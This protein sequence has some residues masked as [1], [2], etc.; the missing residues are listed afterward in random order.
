MARVTSRRHALA[1]VAG[2]GLW[3]VAAAGSRGAAPRFYADD[4]L[5]R[6]PETQD[7]S[8][9][10]PWDIDL[11]VDLTTNLF[12]RPGDAALDVRAQNVNTVDEVPDSGWFTNRIGVEPLSAAQI[13]VGPA[14]GAGPAPGPWTVIRPKTSGYAP[15]FTIRDSAGETW[16]VSFDAPGSPEAATGAILVANK[17]FWA[18]GYH[19]VENHLGRI[20]ADQIRIADT[21]MMRLATGRRRPMMR[22]DVDDVLRRSHR[23]ADGSY[24]AVLGRLLPGQV[25]GGFRYYGTRPDDPNDVVPHEHRRELRALKVF[26]AWTNL[27][28]MKAG[29]TLDTVI[30]VDGRG[31]VRHYLQDIGS[32]FGAGALGPHD[33]DEGWEYLYEGKPLLARLFTLGLAVPR[34]ATVRYERHPSV[35][36]FEGEAF[37]PRRW[38]PRVP[39]AAFLRARPADDFWAARRV[40]AFSDALIDAAVRSGH[41]TDPAAERL[42][43]RVLVQR[44]DKI[45]RAF[46]PAVNPVVDVHMADD[47][48]V[49]FANAAVDA[50]VADA[51]TGYAV[52]WSSFDNATDT[53]TPLGPAVTVPTPRAAPPTPVPAATG[54]FVRVNIAATGGPA[55][56]AVPAKAYFTR[57]EDG[58][59]LIGLTRLD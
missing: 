34:W 13:A 59:R 54:A 56:W 39:T 43:A 41:Y 14:T 32:T 18:L 4:P 27:V 12:G 51:P 11:F 19:Q 42:L 38:K 28:D 6:E 47:G 31:V 16:F 53:A 20:T 37:D 35:G 49:T 58:W 36:R 57:H 44:R 1:V 7:A 26:G 33:V 15:G 23:S 45:A 48:A 40:A 5:A 3:L 55:A 21:A 50:R 9:V 46:L 52:R 25:V 2:L 22:R 17:L 8:T 10:Q 29:N 30:Q 24:R